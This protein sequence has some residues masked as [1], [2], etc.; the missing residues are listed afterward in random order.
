LAVG[1]QVELSGEGGETVTVQV[2]GAGGSAALQL[3]DARG[4]QVASATLGALG[5]GRHE[6]ALD[7]YVS[8]LEPGRYRYQITVTDAEGESVPVRG[9]VR[10][11]VDGVR[12]GPGG[13]TLTAGALEIS[14]ADVVE[15]LSRNPTTSMNP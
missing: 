4:A 1:D 10:A 15:I 7:D 6:I 2:D 5:G 9:Y 8:D 3:F 11:L 14:L 12:F 13:P